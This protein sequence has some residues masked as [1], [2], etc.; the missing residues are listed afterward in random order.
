MTFDTVTEAPDAAL[1]SAT[2]D[3]ISADGC[4]RLATAGTSSGNIAFTATNSVADEGVAAAVR[5]RVLTGGA[6]SFAVVI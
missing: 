4:Y 6:R 2:S 3:D 1:S 5:L